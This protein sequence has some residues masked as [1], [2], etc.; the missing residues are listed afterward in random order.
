MDRDLT[1]KK[2]D[3]EARALLVPG[4]CGVGFGQNELGKS[5]IQVLLSVPVASFHAPDFLKDPDI[6]FMFVGNITR[7][8]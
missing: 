3:I 2:N 7:G 8:C 6:T 4:V 1:I 5:V